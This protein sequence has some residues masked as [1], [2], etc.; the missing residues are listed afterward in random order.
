MVKGVGC[1]EK[2]TIL[3][4]FFWVCKG[5]NTDVEPDLELKDTQY[6]GTKQAVQETFESQI[7]SEQFNIFDEWWDGGLVTQKTIEKDR[8]E[9]HPVENANGETSTTLEEEFTFEEEEFVQD[10]EAEKEI[11]LQSDPGR[12]WGAI[13]DF[14]HQVVDDGDS[15]GVSSGFEGFKL[16]PEME[17]ASVTI[18]RNAI[19]EYFI[20]I[21]RQYL[22]NDSRRVRVKCKGEGCEW[23]MFASVHGGRD[24][25]T[26]KVKTLNEDH[27]CGLVF[28]NI[29]AMLN[30]ACE[31]LY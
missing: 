21:N 22:V 3:A 26:F 12:W 16:L 17:F 28:N 10:V 25:F 23:M 29:H 9:N 13:T 31:T 7:D 20:Q 1:E 14:C 11:G 2:R 19:K 4:V 18:L 30:L 5:G 8:V 27:T 15:D 6:I 24:S